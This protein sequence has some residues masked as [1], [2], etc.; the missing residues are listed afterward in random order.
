MKLKGK[1]FKCKDSP[2][3][4]QRRDAGMSLIQLYSYRFC[5]QVPDKNPEPTPKQAPR[6]NLNR[7][8]NLKQDQAHVWGL[9]LLLTDG[10]I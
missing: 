5:L 7:K 8:K 4:D 9:V 6:K 2:L 3:K 10:F 1:E